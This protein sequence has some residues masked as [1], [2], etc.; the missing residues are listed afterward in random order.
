MSRFLALHL[1]HLISIN[2]GRTPMQVNPQEIG[3]NLE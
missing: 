3:A 2:A 1:P